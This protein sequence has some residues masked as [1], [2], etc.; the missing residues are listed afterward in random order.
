MSVI[1]MNRINENQPVIDY[2]IQFVRDMPKKFREI[3]A[4]SLGQ[5]ESGIYTQMQRDYGERYGLFKNRVCYYRIMCADE[6]RLSGSNL[7]LFGANVVADTD[8]YYLLG[9]RS[10]A[11]EIGERVARCCGFIREV[12]VDC[13]YSALN[14]DPWTETQ[15]RER[16][17]DYRRGCYISVRGDNNRISGRDYYGY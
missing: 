3:N 6:N 7:N 17:R 5:I 2:C 11:E 12:A 14:D 16:A 1:D 4:K 15:A 9:N 8:A 10:S 13:M